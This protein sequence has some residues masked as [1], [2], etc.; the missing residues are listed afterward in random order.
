[1]E[2]LNAEARVMHASSHIPRHPM[3]LVRRQLELDA[4]RMLLRR[5]GVRM[6]TLVGPGGVGKTRLAL[7][8]AEDM[9]EHFEAGA[10]FVDLSQLRDHR[11]VIP[12]IA[13]MLGVHDGHSRST[14]SSVETAIGDRQLLLVLDNFEQVLTAAQEIGTLLAACPQL[15]ILVT[16]RQPLDLRWEW[17]YPV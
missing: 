12:T 17:E 11:L 10:L 1:M 5:P 4:I 3:R 7:A 9:S 8:V 14:A 13:S 6:A 2:S 15:T 16:S